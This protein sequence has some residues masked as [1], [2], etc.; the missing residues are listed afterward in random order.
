MVCAGDEVKFSNCTR[1]WSGKHHDHD[2][3]LL[4]GHGWHGGRVYT[5]IEVNRTD[6]FTQVKVRHPTLGIGWVN[7]W[8]THRTGSSVT[9]WARVCWRALSLL[10]RA[11]D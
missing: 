4:Q 9:V 7:V 6:H 3:R 2:S 5:V 1:I 10:E 11:D 8:R